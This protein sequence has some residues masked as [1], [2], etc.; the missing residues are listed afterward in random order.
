MNTLSI[1]LRN[2]VSLTTIVLAALISGSTAAIAAPSKS[3]RSIPLQKVDPNKPASKLEVITSVKKRFNGR[4]LSVRK[5]YQAHGND[6]HYVK[7]IDRRGELL[8][9]RVGCKSK[10]A[11]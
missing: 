10:Q 11:T 9:I 4:I 5:K 1:I 3:T 7:F 8:L 2:K 6:C